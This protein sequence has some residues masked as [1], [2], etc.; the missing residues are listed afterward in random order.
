MAAGVCFCGLGCAL[1]A[2][3]PVS[4]CLGWGSVVWLWGFFWSG[5][6][7]GLFG[8]LARWPTFLVALA[9]F[10]GGGVG[11]R[12]CFSGCWG[13]SC[14]WWLWVLVGIVVVVEVFLLSGFFLGA[15]LGLVF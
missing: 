11:F 10:L 9:L 13:G 14:V 3:A 2:A 4:F 8:P 7:W 1:G 6:L 5:V 15:L 12:P